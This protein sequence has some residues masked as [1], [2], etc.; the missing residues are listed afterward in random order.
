MM[1][2]K[3]ILFVCLGNICRSPSAEAVFKNMVEKAGLSQGFD[4]D[5]AGTS[6]WH[7]GEPADQRM[8][9]HA[10]KRG[11]ILNSLSRQFDPSTDFDYFDMLIG[12]DDSNVANMKRM[13]RFTIDR[14]KLHKMT[15]FSQDFQYNEVPDPYYGGSEGFELVLDILE[16]ACR[17][18]LGYLIKKTPLADST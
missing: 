2:K 10:Q 3:K 18:L 5:S 7:A 16:D 12:M 4:I 1:E 14:D 9:S 13:A 15:D 6:G 8:R 11:Y 17:G